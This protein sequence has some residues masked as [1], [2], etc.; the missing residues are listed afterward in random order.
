MKN[1]LGGSIRS[2]IQFLSLPEEGTAQGTRLQYAIH[3]A[4]QPK[5]GEYMGLGVLSG[6]QKELA[7]KFQAM[8][9]ELHA[10][11]QRRLQVPLS[12]I[13]L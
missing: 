2:Q 8:K 4:A 7:R 5:K 13:L 6:P 10:E 9:E 12:L 3:H 1:V 11:K